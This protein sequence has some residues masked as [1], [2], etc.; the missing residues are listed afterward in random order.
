MPDQPA[1]ED[2]N[3]DSAQQPAPKQ[4]DARRAL[5]PNDDFRRTVGFTIAGAFVPGLG[6]IA[7][8]RKVAGAIILGIFAAA[9]LG[10]G[11]YALLDRQ[12]LVAYAV[13]PAALKR[14]AVALVIIAL[15]W[16]GVVIATHLSL[17]GT[18]DL[19]P[20]DH[21]RRAGRRV[22]LCGRRADGRGRQLLVH[23]RQHVRHDVQEREGQQERHPPDPRRAADQGRPALAEP[24]GRQAA[25]QHPAARRRRRH[26]P[27]R[28]PDRHGHPG[29]H[30]HHDRRHHAVQPAAQHRPDALP[31]QVEAA[32]T[33][34]P[35]ASPTAT[36]TTPSTSSTRCTTT[37]RPTCPRTCSARPTTSAPTC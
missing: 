11:L 23:H 19:D 9:I 27:H 5:D 29:Q 28:H 3:W 16:V 7:A 22:G 6:L 12:A 37:S 31:D 17:R 4:T 24:V 26:Q 35:T 36:A 8:G 2:W 30:R 32:A 21:R 18:V 20:A 33:T 14:L 13:N 25:A 15:A 1:S 10:L 34:T